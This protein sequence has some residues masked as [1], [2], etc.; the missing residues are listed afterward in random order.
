MALTY[1]DNQNLDWG[2]GEKKILTQMTKFVPRRW[3][4]W[5]NVWASFH[6]RRV[7]PTKNKHRVMTQVERVFGRVRRCQ[8]RV[9][10]CQR[11]ADRKVIMYLRQSDKL[12]S[13]A[14]SAGEK[15]VGIDAQTRVLVNKTHLEVSLFKTT[16]PVEQTRTAVGRR[17]HMGWR[18]QSCLYNLKSSDTENYE[19]RY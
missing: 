12:S 5:A 13:S 3:P 2:E 4:F 15:Q 1:H 9:T 6:M 18:S 11:D 10:S 8:R 19:I 14:C 16:I 17:N 7:L